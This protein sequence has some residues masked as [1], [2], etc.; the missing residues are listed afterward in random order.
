MTSSLTPSILSMRT[1]LP[2][3]IF[4]SFWV[5]RADQLLPITVTRPV[6]TTLS[7]SWMTMPVAPTTLSALVRS[8]WWTSSFFARG[9]VKARQAKETARNTKICS[10]IGPPHRLTTRP[11]RLPGTNHTDTRLG[12]MASTTAARMAIPSQTKSI[13]STGIP[14]SRPRESPGMV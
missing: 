4:P 2:A 12:T 5:E 6:E 9:R 14:L 7:M 13:T 8:L 11:A 10:Q 3:S 1:R